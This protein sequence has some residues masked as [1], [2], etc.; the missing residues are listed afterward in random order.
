M[1]DFLASL[2]QKILGAA[3]RVQGSR[4]ASKE[5][6]F[7]RL[8]SEL[9][10]ESLR[11][12][13]DEIEVTYGD[14]VVLHQIDLIVEDLIV[15]EAR[16]VHERLENHCYIAYLDYCLKL[17]GKTRGLFL[18]FAEADVFAVT[19]SSSALLKPPA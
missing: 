5:V 10:K 12:T 17:A 18:N 6:L 9:K 16:T 7:K 8:T 13:S 11:V 19:A 2:D 1:A 3:K 4:S 14:V 15:V